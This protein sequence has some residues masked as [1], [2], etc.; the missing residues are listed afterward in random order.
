MLLG[1]LS[2]YVSLYAAFVSLFVCFNV[3]LDVCLLSVCRIYMIVLL[4]TAVV[5]NFFW[6]AGG[7]VGA[8]SYIGTPVIW[9]CL[10]GFDGRYPF[11]AQRY[12]RVPP[13]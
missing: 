4:A 5:I 8:G 6:R 10:A 13:V 2:P 1:S 11:N 3:F 7:G 9:K 12:L